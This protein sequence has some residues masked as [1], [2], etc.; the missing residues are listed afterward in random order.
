MIRAFRALALLFP[1]LLTA[2]GGQSSSSSPAVVTGFSAA[3]GDSEVTLSWDSHPDQIYTLYYKS[4]SAVSVADYDDVIVPVTSPYVVTSLTNNFQ[5]SF[6]LTATNPGSIA[7]PPSPIITAV[8]GAGGGIAWTI[9]TSLSAS[10]LLGAAYGN[11][12]FGVGVWTKATT[13][14]SGLATTLSSIVYDGS[15]FVVLGSSGDVLTSTDTLVWGGGTSIAV[16]IGGVMTAIAY[17]AGTYVAVGTGGEIATTATAPPS[18]VSTSSGSQPVQSPW[19]AVWTMQNPGTTQ[20]LNGVSY[21]NGVFVAV[22]AGGTLL[23][24]PRGVNW[25]ARTTNTTKDLWQVAYGAGNYVAVGSEGTVLSSSDSASWQLQTSPTTQGLY[26]ICFGSNS[27]FIA[28]GDAGTI[29]SSDSGT[30]GSWSVATVGSADLYGIASG[31]T[32]VAVG[33]GGA[34][35]S[36]Q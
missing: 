28:V 11:S 17:G 24:S 30:N 5:Y 2:C 25:T 15:H 32:L 18:Q 13:L 8:P 10:A 36:G 21:V 22:G 29:V 16:P 19:N 12:N 20:D 34:T 31:G 6:M 7:G 26:A 1:V 23:T 4:A 35:V 27:K 33:K 9:G 14:P 3:P